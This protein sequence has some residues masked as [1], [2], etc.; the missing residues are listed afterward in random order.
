MTVKTLDT[1]DDNRKPKAQPVEET[2]AILLSPGETGKVTHAGSSITAA[3]CKRL[4]VFLQ[5]HADV[6]AWCLAEM[7]GID[8]SLICHKLNVDPKAIPVK[9]K[10][11][12]FGPECIV[13]ICQEVD[14]L[15]KARFI[16][17][18]RYPDWVQMWSWSPN[19]TAP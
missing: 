7:P 15:L 18:A 8:P 11:R 5:S 4:S 16:S 2:Q 3:E 17:E 9:Q 19:P 12:K 6:F 13:A 10:K 1:R 14:K